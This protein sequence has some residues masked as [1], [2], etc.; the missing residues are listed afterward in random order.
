MWRVRASP[1]HGATNNRL[2]SV[3]E[4]FE[5]LVTCSILSP[6]I[7]VHVYH[8][9]FCPPNHVIKGPLPRKNRLSKCMKP[10]NF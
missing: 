5:G 2:P 8:K 6:K 3:F 9:S 4:T 7:Q 10:N 1:T